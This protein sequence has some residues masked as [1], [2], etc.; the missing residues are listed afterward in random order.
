MAKQCPNNVPFAKILFEH[1]LDIVL[2]ALL[3]EHCLDIV[4]TFKLV[5][6]G[7]KMPFKLMVKQCLN[8]SL[9]VESI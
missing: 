4:Q 7:Q 3:F 6:T 1:C 2:F 5:L 9:N 8:V